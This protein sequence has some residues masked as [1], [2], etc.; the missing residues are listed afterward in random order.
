M[1]ALAQNLKARERHW[2]APTRKIKDGHRPPPSLRA[3]WADTAQRGRTGPWPTH[4]HAAAG[5]SSSPCQ[6]TA[7]IS[8]H[9][10]R[11]AVRRRVRRTAVARGRTASL[12]SSDPLVP[13]TSVT[14]P[15]RSRLA[16]REG[17]WREVGMACVLAGG[18]AVYR[19]CLCV[20]AQKAGNVL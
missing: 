3:T 19:V 17:C 7:A 14:S 11:T 4:T 6:P 12:T 8:L 18:H 1:C 9:Q 20:P 10:K 15:S 13:A 2:G 5:A 16:R